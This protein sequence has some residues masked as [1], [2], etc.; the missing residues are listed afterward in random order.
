M[1]DK[2]INGLANLQ[3]REGTL[4][5][6]TRPWRGR[7]GKWIVPHRRTHTFQHS[8]FPSPIHIWNF[9]PSGSTAFS[10]R[11]TWC[12]KMLCWGLVE[13]PPPPQP[14]PLPPAQFPQPSWGFL[15]QLL[16]LPQYHCC[17]E[18]WC[19]APMSYCGSPLVIRVI[20]PAHEWIISS[21]RTHAPV[22]V[23][24][25]VQLF[26]MFYIHADTPA[27]TTATRFT[28]ATH[29]KF[30]KRWQQPS[31]IGLQLILLAAQSKLHSEPVH[32][33]TQ[34]QTNKNLVSMA[35][36]LLRPYQKSK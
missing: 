21:L 17:I 18:N 6:S 16:G 8:S 19:V 10:L 5:P 32:L 2:I 30:T 34:K 35:W 20:P 25:V 28:G 9:V 27:T 36:Q 11:L 14:A 23:H 4:I 24:F 29:L 12:L 31:S 22:S 1:M 3:P 33:H 13:P 7:W 26:Q 15:L